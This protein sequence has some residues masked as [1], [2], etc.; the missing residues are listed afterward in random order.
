MRRAVIGSIVDLNSKEST[1]LGVQHNSESGAESS[2]RKVLGKFGENGS[3][4]TVG[5][6]DLSPDGPVS[7]THLTLPT[8][9]LV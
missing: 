9:L 4:V 5:G 6:G 2:R 8:I 1:S 7:Y 3:V